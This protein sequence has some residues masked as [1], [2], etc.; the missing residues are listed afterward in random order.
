MISRRRFLGLAASVAAFGGGASRLAPT[1]AQAAPVDPTLSDY[2]AL[3]PASIANLSQALPFTAADAQLQAQTLGIALPFDMAN[4]DQ[5]HE[6]LTGMWEVALPSFVRTNVLRDDFSAIMGFDI[7]QVASGAEIGEPPN[8]VTF[9]RGS[10]DR[11]AVEAV[12][13][14]NGYQQVEIAGRPVFSLF[15]D[16]Q[17]DLT[18]PVSAM[19]LARM[20]NST[21]LDDG[22]LVFAPSLALIEEILLPGASLLDLPGVAPALATLDSPLITSMV[23]G[24]GNFMPAMPAEI[25]QPSSQEE[26]AEAMLALQQ[27]EQAPIVVSAIAGNTPGGPIEFDTRD[28]ASVGSQPKSVSKFALAY[29]DA[30]AATLAA[31]QIDRRLAAGSSMMT[32]QPWSE[33]FSIWSAVPNPDLATVLLTLDWRDRPAR[34][35]QLIAT[36]D[37]VF[38]TG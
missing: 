10:F 12:Q 26:I 34:T 31:D 24:P 20:N 25:F 18:N 15:P 37:L 30:D 33:V 1:G 19:A 32:G 22:T 7:T 8:M 21:F 14:R 5:M 3:S 4:Q 2:L 27:A 38:I 17:L 28:A 11:A 6:W 16:A 23:L 9:L 29:A 35:T 13:I 36:R